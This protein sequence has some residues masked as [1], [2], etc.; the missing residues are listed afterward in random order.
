MNP[1]HPGLNLTDKTKISYLHVYGDVEYANGIPC[2]GIRLLHK[3]SINDTKT[4]IPTAL[5]EGLQNMLTSFP[6]EG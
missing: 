1:R 2:R 3:C 6:L 4:K 5:S